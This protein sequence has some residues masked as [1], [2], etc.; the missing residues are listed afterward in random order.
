MD[1][2]QVLTQDPRTPLIPLSDFLKG[3]IEAPL[4]GNDYEG[5]GLH[6]YDGRDYIYGTSLAYYHPHYGRLAHYLPFRHPFGANLDP[7]YLEAFKDT[8]SKR[9]SLSKPIT[10]HNLQ[11]DLQAFYNL[12]GIDYTGDAWC[13]LTQ[14]Q[15]VNENYPYRK[16]LENCA[17]LYLGEGKVDKPADGM[18]E[19]MPAELLFDYGRKDAILHLELGL[20][21]QPLMEKEK[22]FDYVWPQKLKTL[23]ILNEMKRRGVMVDTDLCEKE[24]RDGL[25]MM[26][27]IVELLG[28]LN[29][30]SPKD[31]E[32]LLIKDLGLP[33]VK[34]NEPT[35]AMIAK[36][37]TEGNPSFD[38]DAMEIYD[39]ILER[40]N[41]T[42]AQLV[43]QYRGWQKTTSS[44]YKAYLDKLSPDGRLRTSYHQHRT[45]TGR[46]SSSNP[47]LQQIPRQSKKV[48]QNKVK[49]SFVGKPEFVL[50]EGDYSQLE[51][52]LSA[53]YANE[54]SLLEVFNDEQRD[55]FDEMTARLGRP[56]EERHETKTEVYTTSYGGGAKRLSQ[57]FGIS[58]AEAQARKAN[59]ETSYPKLK[60]ASD[61]AAFLCKR[62]KKVQL[63][64]GRYRH[65]SKPRDEAHKAFNSMMQG[66]AAD[67]VE[68]AMHRVYDGV[69]NE[70]CRLLMQVHDSLVFEVRE[71]VAHI[72]KPEIKKLME[73]V[74][75]PDG[76]D[77]GVN[78][79]VDVH[80]WSK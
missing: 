48:W 3:A 57:V 26:E 18:W 75:G 9:A 5:T 65:F 51:F 45:L 49:R 22:L 28:G 72:Y 54:Q 55:I 33:V 8:L 23:R 30:G 50:L 71:D 36:G 77:F 34:R 20:K 35:K 61:Q 32:R 10:S 17:Q 12:T 40:S 74:R 59:F 53:A 58:Y 29:P 15:L 42:T 80:D 4:V 21:L 27:E 38:K 47:N 79:A 7:K 56:P 2:N 68:Q 43:A 19:Y 39:E 52:R 44:C 69:D 24:L 46:L 67:I 13:T 66:G 63:W 1:F 78:F 11:Y 31:L 70:D 64:N 37:I 6:I 41:D 60:K 16:N 73:N 76:E 62:N 14:A 25:E